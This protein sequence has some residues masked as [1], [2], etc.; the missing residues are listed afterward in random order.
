MTRSPKSQERNVATKILG[1]D[2]VLAVK[3]SYSSVFGG[4]AESALMVGLGQVNNA[5][6]M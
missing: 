1:S 5:I 6:K 4:K 3:P 2:V